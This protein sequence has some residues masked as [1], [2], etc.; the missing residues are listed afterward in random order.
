M[1]L[2]IE[3]C[4]SLPEAIGSLPEYSFPCI[5]SDET[6]QSLQKR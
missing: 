2:S 1:P 6:Q 3:L 5:G 4:G